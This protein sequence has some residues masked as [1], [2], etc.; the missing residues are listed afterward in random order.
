MEPSVIEN[1]AGSCSILGIDEAGRGPVLGPLVVGAVWLSPG[2]AL[3]LGQLGIKDSKLYGTGAKAKLRRQQLAASIRESC[4]VET[5]C[6]SAEEIDRWVAEG[7]GLNRLEQAMASRLIE[8]APHA[9]EII[10]DGE[11]LFSPLSAKYLQ[12]KALDKADNDYLAVA[13]ASIIA[14]SE[15]DRLLEDLLH[16]LRE[17]F[18]MIRGGGYPNAATAEFLRAYVRKHQQLP[19]GVRRSWGWKPLRELVATGEGAA[20]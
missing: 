15:R 18:G 10:A 2:Q 5:E 16:P 4:V 9:E 13:A 11:R 12:L 1:G 20:S 7:P 8:R 19:Q 6:A 14:K 3:Q 17:D